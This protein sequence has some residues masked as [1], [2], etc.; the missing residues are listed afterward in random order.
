MAELTKTSAKGADIRIWGGVTDDNDGAGSFLRILKNAT[1]TYRSLFHFDLSEIPT[2][3]V[4]SAATITLKATG[5]QSG[6]LTVSAYKVL[7]S[8]N[9]G[10]NTLATADAGE[11][12]WGS[13]RH[14]EDNWGTS[15]CDNT[16]SDRSGTPEASKVITGVDEDWV[17]SP[18]LAT[19]QDWVTNPGSNYGL[20]IRS[21]EPGGETYMYYGSDDNAGNEPSITVTYGIPVGA[22][23]AIANAVGLM[24]SL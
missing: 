2:N 3:A 18:S 23:S 19:V 15:G 24:F 17:F 10:N 14:G 11:V 5:N 20:L 13:A 9:E 16:T 21:D 22:S 1:G 12:T 7:R 4:V 6:N 8:W